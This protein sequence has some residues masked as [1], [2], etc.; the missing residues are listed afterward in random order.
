MLGTYCWHLDI[1]E[2]SMTGQFP[3]SKPLGHN[4]SP[5]DPVAIVVMSRWNDLLLATMML[6]QTLDESRTLFWIVNTFFEA[7][8]LKYTSSVLSVYS[9]NI[10][11]LVGAF[12]PL[13]TY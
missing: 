2:T 5:E 7:W 9:Y 4:L 10:Y 1:K 8:G 12:N 11:I 6:M 13:E 3:H